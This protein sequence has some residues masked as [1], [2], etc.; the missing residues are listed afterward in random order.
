MPR[1]ELTVTGAGV[2]RDAFVPGERIGRELRNKAPLYSMNGAI[3]RWSKTKENA[4]A[5]E[6]LSH[7]KVSQSRSLHKVCSWDSSR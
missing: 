6:Y 7:T 3:F 2:T 4:G 1:K 5:D